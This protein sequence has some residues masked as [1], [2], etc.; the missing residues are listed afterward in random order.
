MSL[1]LKV[2]EL[3][4]AKALEELEAFAR[5]PGRTVD[6]VWQWMKDRGHEL[7]RTAAWNWQRSF[8]ERLMAE[9]F[10]RSGEL[11][12]AIR[13]AAKRGGAVAI[14][15]AAMLQ[16]SQVIFEQAAKLEADGDVDSRDLLRLTSSI[17]S[18]MD[19][20]QRAE[21]IKTEYER[22]TAAAVEEASKAVRN[23]ATGEQIVLR[24]REALGVAA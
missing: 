18:L 23:G 15:E 17:K 11:A 16:L 7:S 13:D 8:N 4:D 6:E 2:H 21:Q 24:L 3:L 1:P 10:S 20:T 19:S 12:A 9:R 14:S 22:R 5:E